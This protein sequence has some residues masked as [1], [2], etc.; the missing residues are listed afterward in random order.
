[1]S[2]S[3][4]EKIVIRVGNGITFILSDTGVLMLVSKG[5]TTD[6]YKVPDILQY[7]IYEGEY[8]LM[9]Y[10]LRNIKTTYKD[11]KL[12]HL[13]KYNMDVQLLGGWTKNDIL[14]PKKTDKWE[15][16]KPYFAIDDAFSSDVKKKLIREK[17]YQ[18]WMKQ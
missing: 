17:V 10:D 9:D 7:C 13:Y 1:M 18:M 11:F 6:K 5:I 3:Q 16:N 8:E 12:T 2:D 4:K 14:G 15:F